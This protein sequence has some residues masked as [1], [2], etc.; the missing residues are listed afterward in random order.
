MSARKG[1]G[2]YERGDDEQVE[3]LTSK[4]AQLEK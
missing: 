2:G 3:W 1:G 4:M